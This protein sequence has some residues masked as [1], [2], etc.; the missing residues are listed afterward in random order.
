MVGRPKL[1]RCFLKPGQDMV[2]LFTKEFA[3]AGKKDP[4]FAPFVVPELRK[5]PRGAPLASHERPN[6]A[7]MV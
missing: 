6:K 5:K 2:G 1:L 3:I 4:P 7:W